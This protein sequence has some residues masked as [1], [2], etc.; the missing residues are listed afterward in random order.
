[1]KFAK[2]LVAA[3]EYDSNMRYLSNFTAPDPFIWFEVDGVSTI[4]VSALEFDRAMQESGGKVTVLPTEMFGNGNTISQLLNICSQYNI[5]TFELPYNFPVGLADALRNAKVNVEVVSGEFVPQ[6]E[7]KNSSEIAHLRQALRATEAG[8]RR[9]FKVLEESEIGK[10]NQIIYQDTPL[11]SEI[12]R[13]EIVLELV[14]NGTMPESTIVA[15][16]CQSA[17]PHCEGYGN[18]Y[19]HQPIVMD[20]FPRHS[21][22][23]YWGDLTRTVVKGVAPDVVKSAFEAVLEAR[24]SAK[25]ALKAGVV[26][27]DIHNLADGILQ[28]HGFTTGKSEAGNYGFFH[29]LGHGVGLDIHEAPRLNS[30]N[31]TPFKCGEVVT[32]EPGVYYPEWGGIRLE[33]M[34]VIQED[35]IECLTEIE[36]FLEIG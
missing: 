8:M 34:V 11:T 21:T 33:D 18:L 22:T 5:G 32:V 30:R 16:G 35:T 9:A 1:M 29:G 19:A 15:G 13:R 17:S 31:F 27:A 10:D 23:G 24:E 28:K 12:L 6:R 3:S 20:I 7:F 36:T 25:Q 4:V 2:L 14:A 26:P